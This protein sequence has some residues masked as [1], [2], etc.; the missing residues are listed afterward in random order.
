M[1]DPIYKCN[2]GSIKAFPLT[3]QQR[4][5]P[6]SRRD[7]EAAAGVETL[8]GLIDFQWAPTVIGLTTS[9]S[10]TGSLY[11]GPNDNSTIVY[12][13]LTYTI[14]NVQITQPQHT[15]WL[16]A[17]SNA[18]TQDLVI[19]LRANSP[20][21]RSS[22]S[23]YI[24]F[25]IPLLNTGTTELEPEYLKSVNKSG[26][27]A[28][29]MGLESCFPTTDPTTTPAS[30]ALFAHYVT[31]FDGYTTHAHTQNIEVFVSTIGRAV[32]PGTL[33]TILN[34]AT[35]NVIELPATF[36]NLYT[37]G[38]SGTGGTA[39]QGT[40]RVAVARAA[41][42]RADAGGITSIS[43][44][45]FKNY[46]TTTSFTSDMSNIGQQ[47]STRNDPTSAYQCVELDPDNVDANKNIRIDL[48]TGKIASSTLEDIL[49]E[50]AVMKEMVTPNDTATSQS[51]YRKYFEFALAALIIIIT[52]IGLMYYF[53]N[54]DTINNRDLWAG[55]SLTIIFFAF[56]IAASLGIFVPSDNIKMIAGWLAFAAAIASF[57]VFMW[58]FVIFPPPLTTECGTAILN[59][60]STVIG[61]LTNITVD[62]AKSMNAMQAKGITKTAA[63]NMTKEVAAAFCPAAASAIPATTRVE[64]TPEARSALKIESTTP[65]PTN[66]TGTGTGT[67]KSTE[68]YSSTIL[69]G[70]AV[71]VGLLGFIIGNLI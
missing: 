26:Q 50:R 4:T 1:S 42:Q 54:Y 9:P 70:T 48:K 11:I 34:G 22:E 37:T 12:N 14:E 64:M 45:D 25:V 29:G 13:T 30:T 40:Q 71:V 10:L 47:K 51:P 67:S 63:R 61:T 20:A 66:S 18:N 21:S 38:D 23:V 69:A 56:L 43:I 44:A 24:I 68:G 15:Q 8:E 41:G 53:D 58:F 57:L 31:C 39:S 6:L 5:T 65:K 52:Y 36:R 35:P 2:S 55:I 62:Q 7:Y 17:G 19:L 49:A 27:A 32:S 16:I 46:I 3:L 33:A 60:S 28:A 59:L